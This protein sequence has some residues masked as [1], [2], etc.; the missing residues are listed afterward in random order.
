ME[1]LGGLLPGVERRIDRPPGEVGGVRQ[2]GIVLRT[3]ALEPLPDIAWIRRLVG[4]SDSAIA[5]FAIEA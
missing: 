4:R 2:W 1:L 3:P 5:S